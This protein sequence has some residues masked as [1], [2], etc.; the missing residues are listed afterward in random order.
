MVN[1]NN[2]ATQTAN[3]RARSQIVEFPC[4]ADIGVSDTERE[5]AKTR[6]VS[7]AQLQRM[8]AFGHGFECYGP[9]IKRFGRPEVLK[10]I[11]DIATEWAKR[12]PA[13]PRLGHLD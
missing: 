7:V 5:K 13:G 3:A 12:Y 10:A 2:Q 1:P 8:V 4:T 9:E 6:D 11:E